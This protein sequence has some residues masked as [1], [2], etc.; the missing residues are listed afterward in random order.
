M[1]IWC[2]IVG[3][4]TMMKKQNTYKNKNIIIND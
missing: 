3:F 4:K 2:F 1:V